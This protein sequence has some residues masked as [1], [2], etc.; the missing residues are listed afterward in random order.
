MNIDS[1]DSRFDPAS[2][3]P[4]ADSPLSGKTIYWL[5]SSVVVGEKAEHF[6]MVEYL[7]ARNRMTNVKEAVSG[8]T[9]KAAEDGQDYYSRLIHSAVLDKNAVIDAFICQISTN[10]VYVPQDWG[11]VTNDDVTDPA[12]FDRRTTLG[13][14]ESIIAYAHD[15][16]HCPIFFFSGSYYGSTPIHGDVREAFWNTGDDYGK[17]VGRVRQAVEKWNAM[18]GYDVR[19][20]DLYNDKAFNGISTED[21]QFYMSRVDRGNGVYADDPIHP[22]KAGYL[23]WWTPYFEKCLEKALHSA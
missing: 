6:S 14:V 22:T 13:G 17:L 16:W 8:T 3:T 10:D 23:C 21:F 2:V 12:C 11:N 18:D 4:R 19:L 7:S 20:I 9:L 5:G 1:N 15:T